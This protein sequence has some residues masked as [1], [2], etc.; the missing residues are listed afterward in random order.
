MMELFKKIIARVVN[1]LAEKQLQELM[2]RVV[3]RL[4]AKD[5]RHSTLTGADLAWILES[6]IMR[7]GK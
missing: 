4:D 5:M 2:A 3:D 6:E 1:R 7:G